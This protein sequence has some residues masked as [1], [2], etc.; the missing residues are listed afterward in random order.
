MP[1]L[2]LFII[3]LLS[4]IFIGF[5]TAFP[6][7]DNESTLPQFSIKQGK[8][9][10]YLIDDGTPIRSVNQ[11][12]PVRLYGFL[13]TVAAFDLYG[14][15][16]LRKTWYSQPIGS[17][18]FIEFEPDWRA[19][20][21][22]DKFGH[23]MHAYFA[24]HMA[25]KA[26]RWAGI[27]TK[28]SIWYGALTGWLWM[29]QIEM[30]DAFFEEWGFSVLDLT[31]N[32]IGVSYATLQQLYPDK[33]GGIRLKIS[34][35]TSYAYKHQ[36]YSETNRSRIDDYEGITLWLTVNIHDI[37]PQSIKNGY[38]GWLAP[39]GIAVGQSVDDIARYIYAGKRQVY[40]GLDFDITKIPF[41]NSN[42]GKFIKDLLNFVR[43]PLPAVRVTDGTVWYG[44]Y[45]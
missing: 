42:T 13:G 37:M 35:H 43:L 38:P 7:D 34:Y 21:Q 33:L 18:H 12:K 3:C 28:S 40:I 39:W 41:G 22:A 19:R 11:I 10:Y 4:F 36:L 14:L 32:T 2:R 16:H 45:F 17:F 1:F 31:S 15:N 6:G 29:L 25:S 44:F 24:T 26:Y 8:P 5:Q 30:I 20:K 9:S 23:M 27:S